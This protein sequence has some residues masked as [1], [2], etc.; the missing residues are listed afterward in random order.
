MMDPPY[1]SAYTTDLNKDQCVK[2]NSKDNTVDPTQLISKVVCL[3]FKTTFL[4]F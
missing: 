2:D 1:S 3:A 4:M